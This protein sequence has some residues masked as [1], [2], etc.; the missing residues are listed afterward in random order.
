MCRTILFRVAV[1]VCWVFISRPGFGQKVTFGAVTGLNLTDDFKTTAFFLPGGTLPTGETSSST[2]FITNASRRFAI[3]PMLELRLPWRLSVKAEALNRPIRSTSRTTISPPLELPGGVVISSF[4]SF[5]GTH[6]DWQFSALGKYRI[7]DRGLKPFAESGVSFLPTEN[8]DQRGINAGVGIEMRASK[9]NIAPAVRYT[10]WITNLGWGRAP[11]QIQFLVSVSER[12]DTDVP[13]AFGR[14]LSLGIVTGFALSTG[15]RPATPNEHSDSINAIG[16]I[17][18]NAALTKK[19][20][21]EVN[22]LYRPMHI[23]EGSIRNAFLTWEFPILLKYTINRATVSPFAAF[24]PTFR[25]IA[26][27]NPEDHSHN[28]FTAEV[29]VEHSL[30]RLKVAPSIRYTRWARD[31]DRFGRATYLS[32]RQDQME[33]VIGFSFDGR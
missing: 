4:P 12:S 22:G 31:K 17:T 9:L 6:F 21:L 8:T 10:R 28:G 30:S 27:A 1:C 23:T 2:T 33:L 3:G 14:D 7:L 11:N 5:M 19:I 26:H 13:K 32:T 16:G 25:V 29:G 18:V 24:G 15:L 20:S